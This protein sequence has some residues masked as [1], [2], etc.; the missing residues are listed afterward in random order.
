[1]RKH[2]LF[3]LFSLLFFLL[4]GAPLRGM[5][6]FVYAS[7]VETICYAVMTYIILK[8]QSKSLINVF[9][10]GGL[11]LL[12]RII[13]EIPLRVKD[14]EASLISLPNTLLACMTI[15][16]TIIVS[17]SKNKKYI[18]PCSLIIWGYCVFEGHKKL[19][20]YCAFGSTP[21]INVA[22]FTIRTQKGNVTLDSIENEYILL[23]FW[24]S[25]CGVCYKKFPQL[26]SFFEKVKKEKAEVIVASVFVPYSKNEQENKGISIIDS[27]G[28]TFPTWSIT[29]QDTLLKALEI[30]GFPTVILLDKDKNVIYK[31][32]LESSMKKLE[33]LIN[34]H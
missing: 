11:I 20:E 23:D 7:I 9:L 10:I 31:G 22:S 1:M 34:I 5:I 8:K 32:S 14:F 29:K 4:I 13:V 15:V 2:I 33:S 18:I 27:L 19:L 25:T 6:G 21:D 26:Q 30:D 28:Y 3:F 17:I 16:L 24:S 12:G